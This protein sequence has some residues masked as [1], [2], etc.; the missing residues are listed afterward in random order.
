MRNG[1]LIFVA[2][3]LFVSLALPRAHCAHAIE[4][5]EEKEFILNDM[6]QKLK[7]LQEAKRDYDEAR[8]KAED[9][10]KRVGKEKRL[11]QESLQNEKAMQVSR[12]QASVN[13]LTQMDPPKAGQLLEVL[14]KDLVVALMSQLPAQKVTKM[15]ENVTP[16]KATQFL[17]Y[18]TRL[19]S[20]EPS[21]MLKNLGL[22]PNVKP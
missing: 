14:D 17:E 9:V 19:H 20:G 15:L 10:L 18:Y 12:V 7:R 1:K 21:A 22:C 2:S 8:L 4:T 3:V 11:Y 13:L 5:K 6:G 16:S